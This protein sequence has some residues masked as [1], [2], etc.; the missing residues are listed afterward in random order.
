MTGL[1]VHVPFCARACPYCDFDFVVGRS[2]DVAGYLA[3]LQREWDLRQLPT[4]Y[5][6]AY[7][8]GGTPSSLG[9]GGLEQLLAWM[10]PRLGDDPPD[11]WTVELNPEHA[12][13]DLFAMLRRGGVDRVSLGVQSFEHTGLQILGRV[14]SAAA[15]RAAVLEAQRCRLRVS[16]DLMLGWPGQSMAVLERDLDHIA[17]AGIEHVSVYALTIEPST[18]WASL[19]RRGRRSEPDPDL[20]A[21]LLERVASRLGALGFDHYEISSYAR[22]GATARHNLGYWQWHDYVGVG[23]SAASAWFRP[24][25]VRRRTNRR[26][27]NAWIDDP[28][29][30]DEE[31]LE[32][33]HAAAEG[34][35][36]GLRQLSGVECGPRSRFAERFPEVDSAWVAARAASEVARGNLEWL[37]GGKL[38]LRPDR[39]LW[40]DAVGVALLDGGPATPDEIPC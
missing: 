16:V 24:G 12:S 1:Y 30:H 15:A 36:T 28:T 22:P 38:R 27:L 23:P 9:L 26:G 40:H 4:G 7:V 35:W 2:P 17:D 11:E 20:Q 18:P 19:V 6:T 32:G 37:P 31:T 8:G 39:W 34:L 5:R 33:A 14:H 21:D 13:A 3:G 29:P 10:R 25:S